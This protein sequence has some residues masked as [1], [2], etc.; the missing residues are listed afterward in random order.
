MWIEFSNKFNYA[1]RIYS[2]SGVT[3]GIFDPNAAGIGAHMIT[4]TFTDGFGCIGTC[5]FVITVFDPPI[6]NVNDN[7]YYCTLAEAVAAS[8]TNDG[9]ELQIPTGIYYDP[10]I[11]VNKSVMITSV[12][13]SVEIQ[14]LQMNGV[15]KA[16]KLGRDIT[17]NQLTLTNGHVRTNGKHL[18]CGTITGGSSTSY[19]ITD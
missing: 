12:G 16:M 11:V 9:D 7:M 15:G 1:G 3:G 8:L 5:T 10:C 6:Y 14:C 2:G 13:G 4:Y 19:V 17:I 18:K